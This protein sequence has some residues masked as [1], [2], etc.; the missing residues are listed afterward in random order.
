MP[1]PRLKSVLL[2][3]AL[4]LPGQAFA[5]DDI[6]MRGIVSD[7]F[8]TLEEINRNI[9]TEASST[10]QAI[11]QIDTHLMRKYKDEVP[12]KG[13]L[14]EILDQ[15]EKANRTRPDAPGRATMPMVVSLKSADDGFNVIFE[16]QTIGT[17]RGTASGFNPP[18]SYNLYEIAENNYR[19][20][21]ISGDAASA[22]VWR[23]ITR[24]IQRG[25]PLDLVIQ[26]WNAGGPSAIDYEV[27]L[28]GSKQ[29]GRRVTGTN[30]GGVSCTETYQICYD[31]LLD[32]DIVP[33]RGVTCSQT[34]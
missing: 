31:Q 33:N 9:S 12:A 34:E 2:S 16:G 21:R 13:I 29:Q 11:K 28:N 20:A 1:F 8:D 10:R 4:C 26:C 17:D 32:R 25:K 19:N 5:I 23:K 7:L 30:S 27:T 18:K 14:E 3:C 24:R 6:T 22:E 15:L